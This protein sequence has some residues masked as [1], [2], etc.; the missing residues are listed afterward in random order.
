MLNFANKLNKEYE[1]IGENREN[2][3][4]ADRINFDFADKL[5]KEQN[6]K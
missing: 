1:I 5:N 6:M 3:Y 2:L 4:F